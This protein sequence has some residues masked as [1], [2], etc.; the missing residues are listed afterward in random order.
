MKSGEWMLVL[1]V[2]LVAT[3]CAKKEEPVH[4][5]VRP[6]RSTVVAATSGSVG[7]SYS[8]QV[9]AR[10]ETKLGFQTSGRVVARL[11]EVGSPVK[12]GQVL[13]R[14]D[15]AQETLR[16]VSA[17]A[18][19]DAARSRVAELRTDLQRTEQ[20]LSKQF[21]SQAELDKQAQALAE[22]ESQLKSALARQQINVNQRGYTEVVADRDGV[23][24]VLG[25]EVGQVVSPG[26][27]VVTVAAKGEREVVVSVP[28]SRVVELQQARQ[29][30][31]S[32]WAQPHKRYEGTLRELAP[33]TD[34]VTRTYS[35]RIAVK[36]ADAALMLGM[37]ASVF[38]PDVGGSSAIRLPLTAVLNK[39]GRSLVWV[40]DGASSRVTPKPVELGGAQND[41]VIV[42][43][44]LA[45]GETVVTAGVHMLHDGQKV[46]LLGTSAAVPTI[47]PTT[48]P[49]VSPAAAP[50]NARVAQGSK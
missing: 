19:V 11:V 7:A 17:V 38:T 15:P 43:S 21:A 39:D 31:V 23:V 36:D 1:G 13:M 42:A 18:D 9:R 14:L 41:S 10:Y 8:G 35:A 48:A 44:G 26:Q 3:A 32:V 37:T 47:V 50:A 30:Q 20:L 24:T 4:E 49:A 28:E 46:A 6:V 12:R 25:A 29:L 16:V 22:A 40:V 2:A 33:D 45:G 34:S 5:D 27:A